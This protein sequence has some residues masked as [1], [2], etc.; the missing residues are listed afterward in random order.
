MINLF[1]SQPMNG[2]TN[3]EILKVREAAIKE[4]K[5]TCDEEVTV[6]E[7]FVQD[8]P[9]DANP[10]WY[11]GQSILLLSKADIVYFASGWRKTRGCVIENAIA[12]AYNLVTIE[13]N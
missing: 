4:V 5:E 10:I 6:I 2:K 13:T 11:L 12:N 8:V 1:I 7:S 3:E 9:H